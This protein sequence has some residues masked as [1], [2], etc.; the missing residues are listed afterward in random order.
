MSPLEKRLKHLK[1][2]LAQEKGNTLYAQDLKETIK[3]LEPELEKVSKD[4]YR[5]VNKGQL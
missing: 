5:M 3:S 2:L 4:G 1:E